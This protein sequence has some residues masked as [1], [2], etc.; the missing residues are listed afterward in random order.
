LLGAWVAGVGT[1]TD[2][3]WAT[4]LLVMAWLEYVNYFRIQL[5]HDTR[6]DLR[7][8]RTTRRLRRS[9]LATDLAGWRAPGEP[10]AG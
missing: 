5:M 4:A 1:V 9:W 8:L 10:H 3:W 6:S 7:R 2:R